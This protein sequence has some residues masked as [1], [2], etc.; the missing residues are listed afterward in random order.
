[1]LQM[2]L[3]FLKYNL[4]YIIKNQG[5]VAIF[6]KG[7]EYLRG[8]VFYL[9]YYYICKII[10]TSKDNVPDYKPKIECSFKFISK[11]DDIDELIVNKYRMNILDFQTK[12]EKGAVAFCVFVDK[13]LASV[14]WIADHEAAKQ[15]IDPLPFVVNFE[16]GEVCSGSAFTD[17]KYRGKGLQ[18][19]I[20]TLM[21]HYLI[22]KGIYICKYSI[23]KRNAASQKVGGHFGQKI[24]SYG[25]NLKILGM[26]FWKDLPLEEVI[27]GQ[28]TDN[29]FGRLLKAGIRVYLNTPPAIKFIFNPI[30]V[31]KSWRFRV[32]QWILSGEEISRKHS[33][34]VVYSGST[35]NKNYLADL[36]FGGSHDEKYLGRRWLWNCLGDSNR[37]YGCSLSVADVPKS[38]KS[39]FMDRNSFIIPSWIEGEVDLP[40][41]LSLF[42]NN[43][44]SLRHEQ[45]KLRKYK[46]YYEVTRDSSQFYHFYR[47][48]YLPYVKAVYGKK[49]VISR[50]SD[51]FPKFTNYE[52]LIVKQE[53]EERAGN[54]L[55][56]TNYEALADVIGIK[57]GNFNY[58]RNGVSAAMY[59]FSFCHLQAKGYKKVNMGA[60]RA[61]L[62]DGVL[63]YKKKWGLKFS[64]PSEK[65]FLMRVFSVTDGVRDFLLNNPFIFM[66]KTGI[67]GAFFIASGEATLENDLENVFNDYL[68]KGMRKFYI[69]NLEGNDI[70]LWKTVTIPIPNDSEKVNT[71]SQSPPSSAKTTEQ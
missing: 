38:L 25:R 5:W 51:W 1:M 33:V 62:K 18:N 21:Y 22:D 27:Q 44:T 52:L 56:C 15:L 58:V 4:K 47:D 60:T 28:K 57:D 55:F 17:P 41:D 36:I 71:E 43:N 30:I 50:F 9:G 13:K 63:N 16:Q 66:D 31:I 37:L 23:E 65:V 34:K 7:F 11:E 68:V 42:V 10:L 45:R 35:Q 59:Y 2:W 26:T 46:Y 40:D 48:M 39:L 14:T 53:G 64:K 29:I 70:K 8:V 32:D 6:F 12:L 61:F 49:A 54:L 20:H 69:Y 67:N 19:Y 24:I 3:K